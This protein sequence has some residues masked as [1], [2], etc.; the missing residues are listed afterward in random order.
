[1]TYIRFIVFFIFTHVTCELAHANEISVEQNLLNQIEVLNLASPNEAERLL[2]IAQ[3]N[4]VIIQSVSLQSHL[5]NVL[6]H[7]FMLTGELDAAAANLLRARQLAKQSGNQLQEAEAL[8]R[9]GILLT[10]LEQYSEALA[11]LKQAFELYS[12]INSEKITTALESILNVYLHL[13]MQDKMKHFGHMLLDEATKRS[14]V[15]PMYSA[16]YFLAEAYLLEND[17]GKASFHAKKLFDSKSENQLFIKVFSHATKAHIEVAAGKMNN[18][19]RSIRIAKKNAEENDF[20]IALPEILFD[21]ANILYKSNNLAE[22]KQK[23]KELLEISSIIVNPQT[24]LRVLQQL[25]ELYE[26]ESDFES[27]LNYTRIYSQLKEK[28]NLDNERQLLTINQAKLGITI[29]DN[30]IKELTLEGELNDQQQTNQLIVIVIS[31]FA[32]IGLVIFS[33]TVHRQKRKL[34]ITYMALERASEAKSQFLAR[35][36]HEIRTP[37]NAIIGLTKL[38]LNTGLNEQQ[39]VNLKQIEESSQTLLVVINDVLDYSK[40]EAGE[41]HISNVPYDIEEVINRSV[42]LNSVKAIEKNIE[43]IPFINRDIPLKLIGDPQRLQQVLNNLV[44]NAIKFTETGSVTVSVKRKYVE[45]SL[46][47]EFEVKDSGIGIDLSKQGRLFDSFT[48]ADESITREYGGTGLGLAICKQLVELMGGT[49]WVESYPNQGSSFFFT[50]KPTET[51]NP[52]AI[53][54][55]P[56]SLKNLKVLIIDDLAISR[57][58]I[59]QTLLEIDIISEQAINGS[60]GI[61]KFRQAVRD[62]RPFDLIILDWKMPDLDGIEVASVIR[63][64]YNE[65]PP[66]I[67]MLASVNMASLKSLGRAVGINLYLEKPVNSQRLIDAIIGESLKTIEKPLPLLVNPVIPDFSALH[68]LLVDDNSIN[69]KVASAYLKDTRAKVSIAQNGQLAIQ[70]LSEDNSIN[71]VLMDIQMPIM[72]GFTA[73]TV[74]RDE[75]GLTLPIIAMTAHAMTNEVNKSFELGMNAHVSK[76]VDSSLLYQAIH[77]ASVGLDL[78]LPISSTSNTIGTHT[79][80]NSFSLSDT[81]ES[82]ITIDRSQAIRALLNDESAYKDLVN[83][84][85]NMYSVNKTLGEV[86]SSANLS[87]LQQFLHT[88]MPSLSYIGVYKLAEFALGLDQDL[89]NVQ[90]PVNA[91]LNTKIQIFELSLQQIVTKLS[92]KKFVEPIELAKKVQR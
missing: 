91:G 41:L 28:S 31:G 70:K 32:L 71:L 67:I 92:E 25:S 56:Q 21:E 49:I 85:I 7:K 9:E 46:T 42:R 87:S 27:A 58:S 64:E 26:A 66:I 65:K 60:E 11:L 3:S 6:A 80:N 57:Q 14:L 12:A 13:Q 45:A 33:I 39:A 37:I 24:K 44:S 88:V 55:E 5:H 19:L 74:I 75:L 89:Q 17:I 59:S 4:E 84:F 63:Q 22:A 40:I 81:H 18:A 76:P 77:Q 16:H 8:R 90:L 10:M 73:T 20:T 79:E 78:G 47:L 2:D 1:M 83:D 72:D 52:T 35:M 43:L 50:I 23:F 34:N 53:R 15:K 68:I 82:L 69:R 29:K 38:S 54:F 61:N 48:Q 86:N 36:S 62:K 51:K 30:Q